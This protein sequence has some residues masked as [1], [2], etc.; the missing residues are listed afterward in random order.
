MELY[1]IKLVK[2]KLV[3]GDDGSI[4]PQATDEEEI[5]PVGLVFRSVGYLGQ[6]LPEIPYDERNGTINNS[7]GRVEAEDGSVVTGIY[8][9]GWIKRGP[10]GVIGT[11]KTC[12]QET[13]G[14]MVEDLAAGQINMPEDPSAE[15]A[16]QL[17]EARQPNAI[18]YPEWLRIDAEETSRGEAAGRPRVKFTDIAEMVSIAKS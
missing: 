7:A 9:A 15:G 14:C 6:P 3:Q 4:R 12:A 1:G 11:N 17:I 10:T 16:Q 18:S 5:I 13:V 2:N 8:T